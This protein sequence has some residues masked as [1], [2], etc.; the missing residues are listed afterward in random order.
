MTDSDDPRALSRQ[1]QLR[2]LIRF[3]QDM[4]E[5][6]KE[7]KERTGDTKRKRWVNNEIQKLKEENQDA[8]Q[9]LSKLA[10]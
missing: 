4:I 10:A 8:Q 2:N 3:N 5:Q 1:Y 7:L 6:L 9:R